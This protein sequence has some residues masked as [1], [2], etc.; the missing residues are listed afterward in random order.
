MSAQRVIRRVT[1]STERLVRKDFP[2][3]QYVHEPRPG[4][5]W[6]R[7]RAILEAHGEIIAYTDDDVVVDSRW[8]S[9]LVRIFSENPEVMAMTGWV[10]P[11]EIE[12]EAQFLFEEYGGFGRGF[13]R[14]WYRLDP[15]DGRRK[16]M[17][18]GDPAES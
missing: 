18:I 6:A 8:V 13:E 15:R 3:V 2:N 12:T 11:Y 7:N 14:K 5:N 10:V 4:L 9:A 16:P 17:H 1:L